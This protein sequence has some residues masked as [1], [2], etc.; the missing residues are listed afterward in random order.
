M[1]QGIC[2]DMIRR[3]ERSSLFRNMIQKVSDDWGYP[4]VFVPDIFAC[5]NIKFDEGFGFGGKVVPYVQSQRLSIYNNY[6]QNL[7]RYLKKMLHE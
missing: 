2:D 4:D 3:S 7:S 5:D 1:Q 6:I